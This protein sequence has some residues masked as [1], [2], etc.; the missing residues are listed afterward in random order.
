MKKSY[1]ELIKL[2][3]YADRFKY[4][5]LNSNVGQETFGEDRYLNQQFYTSAEWKDIR[6][7]VLI[8][9]LGCDLGLEGY[10]ISG[11]VYVHHIN[12]ITAE[13][14][15]NYRDVLLDPEN[16]ICMSM[17]THNAIHYGNMSWI[18]EM[19]LVERRPGDTCPWR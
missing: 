14:I 1:S 11:P 6:R 10:T 2:V 12:P 5:K 17:G 4:L 13:D 19:T 3:T 9:D 16:L 15:I 7:T 8:R 18:D